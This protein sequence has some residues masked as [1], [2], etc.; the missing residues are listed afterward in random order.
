MFLYVSENIHQKLTASHVGHVCYV[1]DV[2]SA[3]ENF[4]P[5]ALKG[6]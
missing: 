2:V 6:Y 5:Q 4:H 3:C 1:N